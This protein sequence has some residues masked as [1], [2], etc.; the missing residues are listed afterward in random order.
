[1]DIMRRW[2]S[3]GPKDRIFI[4][5]PG[6]CPRNWD[7]G[8]LGVQ[9]FNFPNMFMWH[10]KLK[11]MSSRPVYTKKGVC[12]LRGYFGPPMRSKNK[13]ALHKFLLISLLEQ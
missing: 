2:V 5:S 1:M 4:W 3:D 7:L 8:M 11:G 10:I 6:S 13:V 9:T 12:A